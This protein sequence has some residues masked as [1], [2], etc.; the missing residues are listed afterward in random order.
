MTN[1]IALASAVVIGMTSAFQAGLESLEKEAYA[2]A[3]GHFNEILDAEV[4]AEAFYWPALYYRAQAHAAS[5]DREAA[6]EDA[7]RLLLS[8]AA[9]LIKEKALALYLSEDGDLKALRPEVGPKAFMEQTIAALRQN[10]AGDARKRIVGPLSEAIQV[11]DLFLMGMG[12][13]MGMNQQHGML[14]MM[15]QENQAIMFSNETFDDTNRTA[16]VMMSMPRDPTNFRIGLENR[17]G[18]WFATEL[19]EIVMQAPDPFA[20][21]PRRVH[22]HHHGAEFQELFGDQ[23]PPTPIEDVDEELVL[24]AEELIKKLGSEEAPVRAAAR[25]RLREIRR[26]VRPV[27]EK[28]RDDPDPEVQ[29]T[30]RE[31]LQ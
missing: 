24:E 30:I 27:L 26:E 9:S 3:I 7:G 22:R 19:K 25:R 12:M 10:V 18:K 29:M 6:L 15:I 14:A 31:L 2:D 11:V 21:A 28:Y 20:A 23:P 13:N 8:D 16:T 4:P 17:G 5:N 1:I